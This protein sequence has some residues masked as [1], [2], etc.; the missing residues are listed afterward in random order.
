VTVRAWI[1]GPKD[2]LVG[3]IYIVVGSVAFVLSHFYDMGTLLQMGPGY[4]PALVGVIMVGLGVLS[5]FIGLRRKTPDPITKV[6]VE[7]LLLVLAGAL[8]FSYLIERA[9]LFVAVAALLFFAC[10]RR[11]LSNPIEVI[12]TYAV[13]AIFSAGVFIYGFGLPIPMF[14]WQ[15]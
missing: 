2:L 4:F 11:L 5:I 7:P 15:Q 14:W 1:N 8:S 9:G 3:L 10:L 12:A 6:N 13:L